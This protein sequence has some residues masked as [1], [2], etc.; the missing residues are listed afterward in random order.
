VDAT[1]SHLS[2]VRTET[3]HLS[4]SFVARTLIDPFDQSQDHE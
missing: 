4:V 2:L 3:K 1:V